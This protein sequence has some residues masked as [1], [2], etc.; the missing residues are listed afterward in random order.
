LSLQW[1]ISFLSL[2]VDGDKFKSSGYNYGVNGKYY[3]GPSK[4]IDKFYAGIYVRG[5]QNKFENS[6]QGNTTE[7][8]TRNRL[9]AGIS[10]GYKW[11]S[12]KNV[13]FELS[14]G[15]GRKIFSKYSNTTGSVN[16]ADI[17]LLNLDGFF[18]F[19]VGYR[20]GGGSKG[21]RD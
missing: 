11:V 8:F 13:V 20:F 4:G 12:R 21:D 14:S 17:P 18:K 6:V 19:N 3:F 10:L 16:T 9:G 1:G 5:G 7:G 15:I 2:T